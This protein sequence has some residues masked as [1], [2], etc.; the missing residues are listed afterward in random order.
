MEGFLYLTGK[1]ALVKYE[2]GSG[3]TEMV[4]T[5]ETIE[6]EPFFLSI[7][8]QKNY[9]YLAS[10]ILTISK[11]FTIISKIDFNTLQIVSK[12][13]LLPIFTSCKFFC[14]F[15]LIFFF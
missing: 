15:D 10:P 8:K 12:N 5:N 1:F 14:I 7:D 9:I 13:S 2:L 11:N 4:K 3:K 6:E